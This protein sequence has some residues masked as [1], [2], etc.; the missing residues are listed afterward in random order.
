MGLF[1]VAVPKCPLVSFRTKCTTV[2]DITLSQIGIDS[3]LT[4][5]VEIPKYTM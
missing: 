4:N 1:R 3:V 5:M 2:M